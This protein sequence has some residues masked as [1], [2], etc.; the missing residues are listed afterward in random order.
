MHAAGPSFPAM[1]LLLLLP[2]GLLALLTLWLVLLP[3]SIWARY[4]AGR[5][6]RRAQGWVL[7]GNAWLL[8]LS[9]PL[10]LLAA[11]V[12]TLWMDDALR[13]AGWGLLAGIAVGCLGVRLTRWERDAKGWVYTPNRWV[14]LGLTTIVALR[15]VAGLW[16]AWRHLSGDV[17]GAFARWLD[18]G[19]WTGIAGLFLGFGLAY[20][21]GL[22]AR[23]A[24]VVSRAVATGR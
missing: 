19:A 18:A 15:V 21:R 5:A 13:D 1:P 7:G 22:R 16:M 20:T 9:L 8:A 4:S 11:W 6:R 24:R 3:I 17:T 14:V 12:A 10:F 23:L 2:V